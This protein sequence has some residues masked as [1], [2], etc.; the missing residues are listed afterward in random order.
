MDVSVGVFAYNEEKN[1]ERLLAALQK[2]RLKTVN[3]NE[4]IVVS[5]GSTDKTDEIVHNSSIKDNRIKL[6]IEKE[7]K[8]KVSA[9]NK[10]L[11]AAKSDV[12]VQIS[13]DVL[14]KVNAVEELCKPLLDSSTGIVGAHPVCALEPGRT[15]G[16]APAG[17]LPIHCDLVSEV[18]SGYQKNEIDAGGKDGVFHNGKRRYGG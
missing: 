16:S 5:S 3:I 11:K 17:K 2:Q 14:P 4:I 8:G 6:I 13:G 15:P 18:S 7:R 1:I 10:F 12:L 9:I